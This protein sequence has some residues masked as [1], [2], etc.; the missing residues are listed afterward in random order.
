M[1]ETRSQLAI[2]FLAYFILLFF[3]FLGTIIWEQIG[4]IYKSVY[5]MQD[6]IRPGKGP[7][8]PCIKGQVTA[9]AIQMC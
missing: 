7:G 3:V 4:L 2:N 5:S 8:T 1:E 9:K 6:I